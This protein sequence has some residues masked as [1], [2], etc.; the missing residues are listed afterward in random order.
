M[1]LT[2][3]IQHYPRHQRV[4]ARLRIAKA[5]GVSEVFVRSMCN[6]NKKIPGIYALPLERATRGLVPRYVTSPTLYPRR[7]YR[8]YSHNNK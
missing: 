3:Y 2:E 6:G 5:L 8:R 4:A 7:E 1:T